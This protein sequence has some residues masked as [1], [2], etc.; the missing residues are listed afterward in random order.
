M[1]PNHNLGFWV[2]IHSLLVNCEAFCSYGGMFSYLSGADNNIIQVPDLYTLHTP[3]WP[4]FLTP[5][6]WHN[7][8]CPHCCIY[9]TISPWKDVFPGV[10]PQTIVWLCMF[11]TFCES[12]CGR[13]TLMCVLGYCKNCRKERSLLEL[14]WYLGKNPCPFQPRNNL[15]G[16][17]GSPH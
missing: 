6:L 3:P 12:S 8:T 2:V 11:W 5:P 4:W 1:C 16:P 14:L 17:E 7:R 15:T 10:Y 13:W 9:R